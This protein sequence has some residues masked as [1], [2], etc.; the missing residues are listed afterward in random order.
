MRVGMSTR[1][2]IYEAHY[3]R[4]QKAKK[5]G[6]GKILDELV[7]TTS[8]NRD[9]LAHVPVSYGKKRKGEHEGKE[10]IPEVPP[11]PQRTGA[12]EAGRQEAFIRVLTR[13]WEVHGWPCGKAACGLMYRRHD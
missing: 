10:E 8:L 9:H 13:I 7:G 3:R 6:K 11:A 2:K 5:A 12:G 4:Y 1:R